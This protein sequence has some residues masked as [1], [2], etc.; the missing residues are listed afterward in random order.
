MPKRACRRGSLIAASFLLVLGWA[1]AA[2]AAGNQSPW[3]TAAAVR[4]ALA[5]AEKALIIS[6]PEEA[7]RHARAAAKAAPPLVSA[8]RA[9]APVAA[10][11]I[12]HGLEAAATAAAADDG[13]A[14]AAARAEV[15]T[16][17][18]AGSYR[19][20]IVSAGAGDAPAARSWLLVREF[21]K[22]TRFSRPG[23]DATVALTPLV[24]GDPT[25]RRALAATRAD[26][27][28]TY[29]ARL[30]SALEA[31]DGAIELGYPVRAAGSAA[32]A[33]GY[34]DVLASA[35]AG[36]R[37]GDTAGQVRASF[38]RLAAAALD[39]DTAGLRAAR[40]EIDDMLVGFRA[41]P[42]SA[43]EER[44]RAGQFL[45]FVALVPVEY[46]RGVDEGRVT[47][48]FEVQEA[49]TFRDGAAQAFGD[50]EAALA[51]RDE[52]ATARI[53]E[54]VALL[55]DDLA[56]A[57]HHGGVASPEAVEAAAEKVLDLAAGVFPDEWKN[58][59]ASADFDVIRAT[60]DR[61]Q[62]AVATG[63]FS[64]AEQ[65]RLEAY[66]FFEFGPEQRLRGLAPNL[67][68]RS[69]GLFWYG[70]DGLPG[71]VQLL[72]PKASPEEVA[73]TS[74]ALDAALTDAEA[75]VGAGPKSTFAVVSNTAVIV[76]REG[77]EAVLI[78]AALLAGMVGARRRYRKPLLLGAAGALVATAATWAI[79]Q[80][81]LDSLSRYGEKVEVVVGLVAIAVLLLILNWFY[82][83][84]YW[85]D[86][87]SG[88]HG[89]KRKLLGA[90]GVS[91]L[92]A[93]V[94]GL[95]ALGFTSVYREGFETTL[96]L[97]A[98][99]LDVG[100]AR[101]LEGVALGLAATL[102]VGVM[103]I[104]LQRKLPHKKM[105]TATGFLILWVLVV[106]L[107]TTVQ[108][109]QV[110]GWLPVT[111]IDGVRTPYWAGLWFG[112]FPT[113]EGVIAQVAAL[114]VVLGS[115]FLAEGLR[116]RRRHPVRA[117]GRAPEG[118]HATVESGV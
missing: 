105:L 110:V 14:L 23:A 33:R 80:T 7:A 39:A 109:L 71:L 95:A 99:V 108:K 78:L 82:H 64:K 100:A 20:V 65:A 38:E 58:A 72:A 55:G 54:L 50:L 88:L 84:V 8:L 45:R 52:A 77:L 63:Q 29:Q 69:E 67:F 87:L 49:I 21:R 57:A 102:A 36:Q 24:A 10:A 97:Q 103:T 9:H 86:H 70:A 17:I 76:F 48:D 93:Q 60:L 104:T 113:W 12:E 27:L 83:R 2:G 66:A 32:L 73:A 111:P 6:G 90:A 43:E 26:L 30:R 112:I 59:G 117:T 42:L 1:A 5:D 19:L 4:T 53:G 51:Q 47:L 18:L 91:L 25:P 62:G 28:D 13:P 116:K 68:V 74:D 56:A 115:Y 89:R 79:A 96:F 106:M 44:R 34:F 31:L 35:Y 15:W 41:A 3:E 118:E 101:V 114:L 16:A 11:R 81:V 85:N 40:S 46:A 92:T 107:G 37:G 94:I 22:P 98:L 75:A 61:V